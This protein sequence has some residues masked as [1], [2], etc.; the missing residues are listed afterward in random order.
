MFAAVASPFVRP[1]KQ[2]CEAIGAS[3]WMSGDIGAKHC[4]CSI[5]NFCSA[6]LGPGFTVT[7]PGLA[8]SSSQHNAILVQR[9]KGFPCDSSDVKARRFLFHP[10]KWY[11]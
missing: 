7:F 9:S 5:C 6:A 8:C 2:F 3:S 4:G 10:P 11:T 1:L